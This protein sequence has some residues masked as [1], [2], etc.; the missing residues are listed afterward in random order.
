M[1]DKYLNNSFLLIDKFDVKKRVILQVGKS[2]NHALN[3][4]PALFEFNGE[5]Y[6]LKYKTIVPI[7]T[8]HHDELK[9]RKHSELILNNGNLKIYTEGKDVIPTHISIPDFEKANF[10]GKRLKKVV[11]SEISSLST[12]KKSFYAKDRF[13]RAII[14]LPNEVR[15][16]G[17]FTGWSFKID[18]K[19]YFETL[20]KL[21]ISGANF[22]FYTFKKEKKNYFVIDSLDILLFNDF[23]R[24]VNSILLSYAFLKGKYYGEIAY[25]FSYSNN[26]LITPKS[27][28]TLI[29]GGGK[30][31]GFLIHTTN[32]YSVQKFRIESKSKKNEVGKIITNDPLRK[33]M[34]EFPHEN[35]SK[36]CELI[37]TKG[38]ILRSVIL[39]VNNNSTTLEMKIPILY[40][41]L[42][43]I[44]KALFGNNSVVEKLIDNEKI[45]KE[46]KGQI[47]LI[48][49][50]INKIKRDNKPSNLLV[51]EKKAYDAT[52][53]RIINK[54][55]N[56]N[57]G[58]NNQKLSEPFS[59]YGYKLTKEEEDLIIIHRNKF[60]HGDDFSD[61][62]L[63]YEYEFRELFH[64]SLKLQKL[65]SILLLKASGY[66]G[67]ILN[68]TKNYDYISEKN[69]NESGFIKI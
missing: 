32:P 49:K 56:Y 40:V 18:N 22:D 2:K 24:F 33:Y 34:V 51:A 29:L 47:K 46:I 20:M 14:P 5:R 67:Y 28:K 16:F 17:N 42:E 15:L 66:S 62:N 27:L 39:F 7:G 57:K 38:G 44:T 19:S 13:Y 60:L 58:T 64:I 6:I 45:E 25:V 23:M 36:L 21:R 30:Y 61:V 12:E 3:S 4:R 9:I 8:Q 43:N 26:K 11:V 59:L 65:I 53:E 35:F 31:D 50:G 41:A 48:V 69:L 63:H 55:Y 54:F 37:E 10:I 52:F 68:N 1:I